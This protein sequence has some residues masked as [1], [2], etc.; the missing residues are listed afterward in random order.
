MFVI[1]TLLSS[2]LISIFD[3][4]VKFEYI[5][6]EVISALAT[7]GV[8]ANLTA[9]LSRISQTILMLLMIIGRIGPIT[10]F[11]ALQVN[12]RQKINVKYAK[13]HVLIG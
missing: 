10:F 9:S 6:F 11:A 1:L 8:S 2:F 4:G 3:M 5:V 13:G 7:V 12:K